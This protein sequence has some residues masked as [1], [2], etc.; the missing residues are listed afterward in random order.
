MKKIIILLPLLLLL[1]CNK[2]P[3]PTVLDIMI[4]ESPVGGYM[5]SSLQVTVLGTLSGEEKPIN[6]TVE[7]WWESGLHTQAKK[8]YQKN[9]V[10]RESGGKAFTLR[11]E[12]D[13]YYVFQNYYWIKVRW[14]DDT[15]RYFVES[16]KVFCH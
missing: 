11:Y 14:T 3:Q 10:F 2:M 9:I 15:G 1:G 12:T 8:V 4:T 7:W 13:P 5:V 16:E 6:A